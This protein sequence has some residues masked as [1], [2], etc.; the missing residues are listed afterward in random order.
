MK[1]L[2][3]YTPPPSFLPRRSSAN[4]LRPL[5]GPQRGI[6][7][8]QF[9]GTPAEIGRDHS[10]LHLHPDLRNSLEALLLRFK[11]EGIPF[12]LYEGFRS[13]A[14]QAYLYSQDR[15]G[16]SES[17]HQYGLAADLAL[18]IDGEV[19]WERIPKLYYCWD[20][21][22][23]LAEQYSLKLVEEEGDDGPAHVECTFTDLETVSSGL[24]PSPGPDGKEWWD[25]I[26]Q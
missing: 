7:A 19:T 16:A 26:A 15:T 9:I 3:T 18:L 2:P 17:L 10:L 13:Q 24:L 20:A 1:K 11:E 6:V 8:N 4:A 12:F 21:L 25:V 5:N 14:R 22:E 23:I